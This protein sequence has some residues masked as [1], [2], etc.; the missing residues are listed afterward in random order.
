MAVLVISEGGATRPVAV[1]KPQFTIGK[2]ATNDLVLEHAKVSREH[3]EIAVQNGSF[4]LRDLRSRNGTFLNGVR[5]VGEA[6]LQDGSVIQ[7]ADVL[8]ATFYL[9]DPSRPGAAQAPAR[10]EMA[11]A[12]RPGGVPAVSEDQ[13]TPIELKKRIHDELLKDM[14][15][16]NTDF[17][18]QTEEELYKRTGDVV[19]L[20]ISRFRSDLPPWLTEEMLLKEIVDEALG[21]GPLEDLLEDEEI[22][23]IMVNAWDKIF[24]ERHGKLQKSKKRFTGNEQVVAVIRR[25]IAPIGRRIDET[26]PMVDARLPDGS[27]VNAIISPLSLKGPSLTIRK[28]SSDPFTVEDLFRH[29]ACGHTACRLASACTA[30]ATPV[31][32]LPVFVVVGVLAM[33]RPHQILDFSVLIHMNLLTVH[34]VDN[35]PNRSAGGYAFHQAGHKLHL[36]GFPAWGIDLAL[37]W[38]PPIQLFL[39][40]FVC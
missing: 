28:F 9:A 16:K 3:C 13:Q 11:V 5:L 19:R 33:P 14:D 23:E 22:D 24:V 2:R 38:P 15:L 8:S 20:I 4:V 18:R 31:C 12:S 17:G 10:V 27:R 26:N 32:V 6:L 34:I 7:V 21:L 40:L 36:I 1:D 29:S 25:I 37:A 30:R 35:H 39:Y